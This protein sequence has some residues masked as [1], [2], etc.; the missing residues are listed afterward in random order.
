MKE[1]QIKFSE[2]DRAIVSI[3][4]NSETD[5][6]LA[7]ISLAYGEKVAPGTITSLINKGV[8]GKSDE[9]RTVYRP[10]KR[11]VCVYKLITSEPQALNDKGKIANYSDG[12]K[13][14]M[15]ILASP[16][17]ADGLTL[18]EIAA[19]LG[20]EKLSSGAINGLVKK[21]NVSNDEVREVV[22]MTAATVLAYEFVAD[23]AD[24]LVL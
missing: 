17:H 9:K 23:I 12:E 2:K 4:K 14:I 21:G 13:K 10:S 6:T 1:K 20:V 16:E 3:L 15:E 19:I 5:L 11:T 18:A 22:V 24:Q 7:E 8:V